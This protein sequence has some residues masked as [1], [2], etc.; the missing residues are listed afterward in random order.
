MTYDWYKIFNQTEFIALGLVSKTY[1][2]QLDGIGLR[3]I[4]VT[5]SNSIS[6][7]Y[8]GVMLSVNLNDKNPFEMSDM[9]AYIDADMNV[10]LGFLVD[11]T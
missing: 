2:F 4:L 7:T 5:Y 3:D 1:T 11:E 9:A 10:Y 6:M 8:E